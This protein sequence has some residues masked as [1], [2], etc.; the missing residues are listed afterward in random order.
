MCTYPATTALALLVVPPYST[1]NPCSILSAA[2]TRY[3]TDGFSILAHETAFHAQT[4]VRVPLLNLYAADDSL[5]PP[6]E[7]SM[8]AAYEAGNPLQRTLVDLGFPTRAA[9]DARLAPYIC[10]TR[11]AGRRAAG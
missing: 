4:R 10:A 2:A 7:A 11:R 1:G 8:M 3:G 9:A 5:V 6:F